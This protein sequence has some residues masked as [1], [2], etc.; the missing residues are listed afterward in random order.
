ML[1]NLATFQWNFAGFWF[2]DGWLLL[3]ARQTTTTKWTRLLTTNRPTKY[4]NE[5]RHP[6]CNANLTTNCLHW[7]KPTRSTF[8]AT[9]N[10]GVV[11][12]SH[13]SCMDYQ[14]YTNTTTYAAHSFLSVGLQPIKCL[15]TKLTHWNRWLTNLDKKLQSTENFTDVIK[16]IQQGH[17]T[18]V[19]WETSVRSSL[20]WLKFSRAQE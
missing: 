9:T 1:K 15:N 11:F 14:N 10:W 3:W 5:T 8:D 4:L 13:P 6:H 12:R 2:R 17:P 19:F 16:T 7:R 18:T 20:E